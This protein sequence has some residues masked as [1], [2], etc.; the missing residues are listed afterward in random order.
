MGGM[1]QWKEQAEP[2]L[3]DRA[4]FVRIQVN[5]H[6]SRQVASQETQG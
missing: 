1:A 3:G 6:L 2:A 5:F 4:E